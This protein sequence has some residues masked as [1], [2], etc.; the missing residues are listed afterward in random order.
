MRQTD[1]LGLCL[2]FF[3]GSFGLF[4]LLLVRQLKDFTGNLGRERE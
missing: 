1:L 3:I 2:S 4:E